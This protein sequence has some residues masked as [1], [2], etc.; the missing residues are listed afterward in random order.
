MMMQIYQDRAGLWRW[1]LTARNGRI[2]A[3]SG[4]G[5]ARR[6]DISRALQTAAAGLIDAYAAEALAPKPRQKS[7]A[8]TFVPIRSTQAK[9]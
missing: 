5:Y 7:Q 3:E 4:E 8:A 6:R 1:R 9:R 2:V